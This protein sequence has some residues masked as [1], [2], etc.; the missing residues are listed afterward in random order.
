M[1]VY[2]TF[3]IKELE[4]MRM[5]KFPTP[6]FKFSGFCPTLWAGS[7]VPNI[8]RRNAKGHESTKGTVGMNRYVVELFMLFSKKTLS[9]KVMSC[10]QTWFSSRLVTKKEQRQAK[11]L[12]NTCCAN[13][14]LPIAC[15]KMWWTFLI[16][17]M[18]AI[19]SWLILQLPQDDPQ[20][21]F[22]TVAI[23]LQVRVTDMLHLH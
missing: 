20:K 14:R 6:L 11:L 17:L 23:N 8:K 10:F 18:I 19:T 7:R 2:V 21:T 1:V 3:H 15:L 4:N 5:S 13:P 16:Y 22:I 9:E 12:Y